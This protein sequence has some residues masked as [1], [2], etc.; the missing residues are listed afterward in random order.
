[1]IARSLHVG[2]QV[3]IRDVLLCAPSLASGVDS[4]GS[5]ELPGQAIDGPRIVNLFASG[6]SA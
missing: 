6:T 4:L 2:E 5:E 3:L 1:M